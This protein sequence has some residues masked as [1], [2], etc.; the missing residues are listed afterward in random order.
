MIL[1][2]VFVV[3]LASI[4]VDT[5]TGTQAQPGQVARLGIL[6][7]GRAPTAE[8]SAQ[9]PFSVK[10]RELGWVEGRN[11]KFEPRYVGSA[12]ELAAAAREFVRTKVDLVFAF[13][14]PAARAARQEITKIPVVIFTAG[15]PV[16]LG[17]VK[18][19]ARPEGNLTGVGGFAWELHGKRLVLLK[20]TVPAIR[21]VAL[22]GNPAN[23]RLPEIF[24]ELRQQ[25]LAD[26]LE[27]RLFEVANPAALKPAFAA[28][29]REAIQGLIEIPDPMIYSLRQE[30]VELAT[31][32][33]LP[34][35][36]E[37][38]QAAEAGGLLA[39]GPVYD[40][41]IRRCAVY[42]DKLLRGAKPGDL[43]IELPTE[44]HMTVNLQTA[45]VL[46]IKV[47]QSILLR[48]DRV[49]E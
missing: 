41:L 2:R 12:S 1:G 14:V 11:L 28:I 39:Y 49:I 46:G 17:L 47:P 33:N 34:A 35:I 44:F 48:A 5:S 13:G 27:V 4:V 19:L 23:T 3:L 20:E 31:S 37:S 26:G 32:H 18:S 10:L 6:A 24:R 21:R 29:A 36:Y 38:R 45:K 30:I 7:T 43:P 42:V 9:S 25:A 8:E 22:L 15:D 40:E 16:H